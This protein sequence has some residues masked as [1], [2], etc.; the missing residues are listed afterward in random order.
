MKNESEMS[1]HVAAHLKKTSAREIRVG[2]CK[3]DVVA[4]DKKRRLFQIAECKMGSKATVIGHAFGQIAAYCA[5]LS[6]AGE[7][8]LD[9]YTKRVSLRWRRMMEA[10]DQAKQF[11]VVF[12]V[13][14]EDKACRRIDLIRSIKRLLPNV[15]IIRVKRNGECRT[16]LRNQ[17]KK[18]SELCKAAPIIVRVGGNQIGKNE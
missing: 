7:E 13:A 17:R 12:Y 8:F 15:G 5:I 4:Y 16:H 1:R 10:T 14:L 11:K 9:A 3:F 2:D 18:E 6:A